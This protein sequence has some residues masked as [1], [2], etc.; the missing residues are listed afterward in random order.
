MLGQISTWCVC[1]ID[2]AEAERMAFFI[3]RGAQNSAAERRPIR[4]TASRFCL[5]NPMA[6]AS[7]RMRTVTFN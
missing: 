1:H 6:E 2:F 4:L 7:E 5:F 3:A